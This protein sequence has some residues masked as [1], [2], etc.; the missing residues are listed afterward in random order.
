MFE[1]FDK[2]PKIPHDLE[3]EIIKSTIINENIFVY[4][5]YENYKIY[6]A[7]SELK[8]FI[9][10]FFK[11]HI[12]RVQ[13]IEKKLHIHKD[14][15]RKIKFNYLINSGGSNVET[16]FYNN[17]IKL[18]QKIKIDERRWHKLDVSVLHNV[19]NLETPRIAVTV[20]PKD[21]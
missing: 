20:S 19:I 6:T 21:S 1:Y 2:F 4:N 10:T 13:V 3:E 18:T 9:E 5:S 7:T 8:K 12:I 16:C 15:G 17:K 14:I 11:N